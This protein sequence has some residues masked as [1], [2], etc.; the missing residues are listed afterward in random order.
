MNKKPL[1]T[2]IIPT[3]N[4]EDT[5]RSCFEG[6]FKQTLISQTEVIVLDSASTDGTHDIC[7]EFGVKVHNV[8]PK[9]FN[10]GDTRNLGVELAQGEFIVMTTQDAT[11]ADDSWLETMLGNFDNPEVAGVCGQQI[12][13][14]DADKNPTNW[15][16]PMSEAKPVT[17]QFK[18]TKKFTNLTGKEQHA[19]CYWDD[20]NAMYRKSAKLKVPFKRLMFSE[21]TLWAKDALSA[22]FAIVYD[23]RA[24]VYHYHHQTFSFSFKRSYIILYSNYKFYNYITYPKNPFVFMSKVTYRILKEKNMSF[25]KKM[26]WIYY[27]KRLIAS[28]WVATIIFGFVVKLRGNK[29]VE[30]SQKYF[31]GLPP[32][33]VQAKKQ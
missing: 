26:G 12:V 10:H 3:R 18:D 23:Y 21:D 13:A 31:V 32:Q 7:A 16:R 24:R 14:H 17:Y 25:G 20:V 4:G 2:I 19:Y 5:I 1:I 11:P 29:G 33:G 8:E 22:G 30:S 15:F 6:I 28:K 27:N 9:D